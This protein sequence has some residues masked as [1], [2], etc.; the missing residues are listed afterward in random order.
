MCAAP[1]AASPQWGLLLHGWAHGPWRMLSAPVPRP[2]SP[3]YI[4][5]DITSPSTLHLR[6]PCCALSPKHA[7]GRA[8]TSPSPSSTLRPF[9]PQDRWAARGFGQGAWLAMGQEWAHSPG[10]A[11]PPPPP[12]SF[13]LE[14]WK[15]RRNSWKFVSIHCLA[16]PPVRKSLMGA[17]GGE[18]ASQASKHLT[19]LP[20]R[21]IHWCKQKTLFFFSKCFEFLHS[22]SV[23]FSAL[24]RGSVM[25]L[26]KLCNESR[27]GSHPV[28]CLALTSQRTAVQ[29]SEN[30]PLF[31]NKHSFW[32][33][34]WTA[35]G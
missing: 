18:R 23:V 24:T 20:P 34:L 26:S 15:Q 33:L 29:R 3:F 28:C 10:W 8:G 9:L 21:Y 32:P 17:R 1:W 11:S 16:P 5:Q 13:P 19:S 2:F 30:T 7:G 25:G 31:N 14:K 27:Q 4:G 6:H 35:A 12:L 22:E